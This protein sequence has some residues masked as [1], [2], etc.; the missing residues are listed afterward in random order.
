MHAAIP[1]RRTTS[2]WIGSG[3][4]GSLGNDRWS[5]ARSR[6]SGWATWQYGV[7]AWMDPTAITWRHD[8]A[9]RVDSADLAGRREVGRRNDGRR[10]ARAPDE[11]GAQ[12]PCKRGTRSLRE[13]HPAAQAA[14]RPGST[15]IAHGAGDPVR[16]TLRRRCARRGPAHRRRSRA[17]AVQHLVQMFPRSAAEEHGPPRHV[18]RREESGSPYVSG[19]GLR[20]SVPAADPSD[21]PRTAQGQEQCR[22][23]HR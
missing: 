21:R 12:A 20:R 17:R 14:R 10:G 23:R 11:D 6:S 4:D 19:H 2:K 1:S 15:M 3:D 7:T 5:A 8:F 9:R 18:R 22:Q 13:E 16:G